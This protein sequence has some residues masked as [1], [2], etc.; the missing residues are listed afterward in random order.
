MKK[1]N[2]IFV[3][4]A[5]FAAV[6]FSS[7]D[8]AAN[9]NNGVNTENTGDYKE[10][11]HG[12]TLNN[13]NNGGNYTPDERRD[14]INGGARQ[15]DSTVGTTGSKFDENG[16]STTGNSDVNSN[17]QQDATTGSQ[18]NTERR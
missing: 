18:S 14:N 1:L 15:G 7:C 13:M 11:E 6:S 16:K 10:G 8:N 5:I 4:L 2:I 9:E 3:S 17:R 12:D